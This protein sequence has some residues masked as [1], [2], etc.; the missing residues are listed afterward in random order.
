MGRFFEFLT[1]SIQY[2]Y[3]CFTTN[4]QQIQLV[5]RFGQG[6]PQTGLT[7]QAHPSIDAHHVGF[8][9]PPHA[10]FGLMVFKG[11]LVFS[12]EVSPLFSSRA[13]K[14]AHLADVVSPEPFSMTVL[15][16]IDTSSQ[17]S[18]RMPASWR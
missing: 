1:G 12:T 17:S 8:K 5:G 2:G 6:K 11:R 7:A 16:T 4:Q 15:S 13:L 9:A 14:S 3:L 18:T 10:I